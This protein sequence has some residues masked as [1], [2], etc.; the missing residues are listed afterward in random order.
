VNINSSFPSKY[1]KASELEDRE[2]A[3]VMDRVEIEQMEQGGES[4]PV[5]YFA[6]GK[7]GM[8]LNRT[9]SNVIAKAYGEETGGWCGKRI[10]LFVMDV[11]FKGDTVPGLR[12]RV[13]KP[14][15][16]PSAA[17]AAKQ[18]QPRTTPPPDDLG[19]TPEEGDLAIAEE[20]V[21]F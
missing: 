10:I 18:S 4:K 20:E 7:K 13:P 3:M 2:W 21:P 5:L 19:P 17:A 8:V 14:V 11:E 9:N 6:N 15:G 12:V 16:S 1:I